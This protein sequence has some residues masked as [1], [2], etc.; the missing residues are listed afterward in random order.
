MMTH[1]DCMPDGWNFELPLRKEDLAII[2]GLSNE[3][4]NFGC[5]DCHY[6]TNENDQEY[7]TAD[8]PDCSKELP[9]RNLK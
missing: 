1:D 5:N 8:W 7:S 2:V 9:Y 4:G 6:R 3:Q